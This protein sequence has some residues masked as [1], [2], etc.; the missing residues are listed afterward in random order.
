MFGD[1]YTLG[2]GAAASF[3]SSSSSRLAEALEL[4]GPSLGPVASRHAG[5]LSP[6]MSISTDQIKSD[7]ELGD[8]I[9]VTM[10]TDGD[11][12]GADGGDGSDGDGS[13][14]DGSDGDGGD[15]DGGDA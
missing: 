6:A 13:D 8:A 11:G 9:T 12:D 14:G 1:K 5:V 2:S 7:W 10:E 3:A 15:A 4:C